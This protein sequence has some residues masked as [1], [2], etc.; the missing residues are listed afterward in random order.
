MDFTHGFAK[1]KDYIGMSTTARYFFDLGPVDSNWS[2]ILGGQES[3][4]NSAAEYRSNRAVETPGR[5][6]K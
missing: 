1:A 4:P 6:Y 3:C 2:T 5:Y